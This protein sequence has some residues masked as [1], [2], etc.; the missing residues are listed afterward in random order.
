MEVF[1]G[2]SENYE[3]IRQDKKGKGD[4]GEDRKY[5]KRREGNSKREE[6]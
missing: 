4:R 6:G 2:K 1:Q 3:G 5:R